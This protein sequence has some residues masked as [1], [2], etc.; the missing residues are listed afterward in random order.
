[1][2]TVNKAR[3][4]ILALIFIASI[5]LLNAQS[6]YAYLDASFDGN[7]ALGVVDNP[8]TK[9]DTRGLDWDLELGAVDDNIGVY[10]F[11]GQYYKIN[12]QNYGVGIDYHLLSRPSSLDLSGGIYYS[13]IIREDSNGSKGNFIAWVSPRLRATFWIKNIGLNLTMKGQNRPE[14]GKTVWE[15]AGGLTFKLNR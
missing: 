5:T 6:N 9:V 8:R 4:I 12:Y 13:N 2:K 10:V 7:K 3:L 15:L 14:L 1:M 11:Y